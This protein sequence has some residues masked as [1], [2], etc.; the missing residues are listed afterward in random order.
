MAKYKTP[1][2]Q[3]LIDAGVHF[4]HQVKRW[5][6]SMEPYIYTARKNLHIIDLEVTEKLLKEASDFLFEIAKKGGKIVFVGTKKQARDVIEIEAKNSGA[7]YVTERWLGGTVTNFEVIKKNNIDKLLDLKRKKEE[8]E[9][10]M[11][12]KKERLLIDREIERLERFVGGLTNLKKAPDAMVVIDSR[13]EKT[14]IREA[15]RANIPIVALIDTNCDPAGIEYPVPGNDDA[16]KSIA[17]VVKAMSEA[18][19]EGYEAYAKGVKEVAAAEA[20]AAEKQAKADAAEKEAKKEEAKE[21]RKEKAVEKE[22]AEEKKATKKT[23]AKKPTAKKTTKKSKKEETAA[24]EEK[25]KKRGR[26]KKKKD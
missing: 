6:P 11:Y 7:M 10:E 13:R 3:D 22:K 17:I 20:K 12:T 14:A 8:G 1:K 16:I 23:A 9:L 4:G 15:N 5:H 2:I 21:D 18:V 24:K 26:P 25:P 19:A